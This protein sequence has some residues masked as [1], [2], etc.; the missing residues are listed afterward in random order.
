MRSY[1][2]EFGPGLKIGSAPIIRRKGNARIRLGN[3]VNIYNEMAENPAGI[4]HPTVLAACQPGA[5][6]L[7]G[8]Q[9]GISGG[10]FY[11]WRRIEIGDR[12]M[13]GADAVVY[14]T[15][16]HPLD[17]VKRAALDE[18]SVGVAPVKIESDVWL[19]ARS[20]VLKGVTIGH[21]SIVAAG[22][23]VTKDVPANCIVAGVPAK[24]VGPVPATNPPR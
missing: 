16:F 23:V 11:A 2:V 17:P 5:E 12:V 15:D 9:V 19:G 21:G 20:M 14:D 3:D 18:A 7:I 6:L 13:V 4:S 10:I 24:V 8:N 1:G 22:A